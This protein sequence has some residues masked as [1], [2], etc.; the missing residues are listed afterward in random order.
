MRAL[1]IFLF[2][3]GMTAPVFADSIVGGYV[4]RLSPHDHFNS[5]GERLTSAAAVLA[6]DRANMFRFQTP[7]PADEADLF[8]TTVER[9][10]MFDAMLARGGTPP[11]VLDR[12]VNSNPLVGVDIWSGSKGPYVVV[13]IIR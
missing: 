8:F 5:S 4:A 10:Q 6:Q 12:I 1:L 2:V 3:A 11:S 7:D 13:N 9:R